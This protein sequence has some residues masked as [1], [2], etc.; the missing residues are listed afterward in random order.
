MDEEEREYIEKAVDY[1][2]RWEETIKGK[3]EIIHSDWSK[4]G[5]F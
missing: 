4:F 5:H 1:A 3:M 2:E